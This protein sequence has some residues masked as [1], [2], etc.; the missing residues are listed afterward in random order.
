MEGEPRDFLNDMA[1]DWFDNK[2]EEEEVVWVWVC[3][4][5]WVCWGGG[6]AGG[7]GGGWNVEGGL[8]APCPNSI[9]P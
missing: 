5:V 9:P 7:G 4:R 6:S 8:F 1:M 2:L 3:V